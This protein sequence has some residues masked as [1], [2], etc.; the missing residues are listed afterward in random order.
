MKNSCFFIILSIW[1]SFHCY[2]QESKGLNIKELFSF[3]YGRVQD[4]NQEQLSII[5]YILKNT[6]EN[7]IHKMRGETENKVY[8]NNDGREAVFD[9]DGNLVTNSYN[10]G[11]Y[12]YAS[13]DKPIEKFLLDIAPWLQLGNARD[14]PTSFNERLYYYTLDLNYGIQK[15]IF[16]GSKEKSEMILFNNL[17]ENEKEV[18]YI[19]IHI[20]FNEN[21]KIKLNRENIPRL[22]NDRGYYFEYFYQIQDLIKNPRSRA[23]G[24]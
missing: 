18:Y 12:N 23:A 17:S 3:E 19:F 8:T 15:Y 11:S 16:E 24:Y 10:K 1:F 2:S 4:P 20:I 13:Y 6:Y 21:Y 7:N 9:K 22:V 14:D 5:N